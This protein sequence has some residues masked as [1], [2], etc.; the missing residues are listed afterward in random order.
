M[1]LR[2]EAMLKIDETMQ[3]LP[4]EDQA[5][6]AFEVWRTYGSGVLTGVLH[7][8]KTPNDTA[9]KQVFSRQ[10]G[11]DRGGRSSAVPK[12]RDPLREQQSLEILEFLNEKT[13]RSYRPVDENL[14][15]IYAR[16]NTCSVDDIK[17]VIARKTREWKNTEMEKYLRP[18]TLFNAHKF[19]QYIGEQAR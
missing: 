14:R 13:G 6:V 3:R 7:T 9:T 10:G 4:K 16:L 5:A 11:H 19:E 17:G 8:E 1:R 18:A 2:A 12:R 15:F